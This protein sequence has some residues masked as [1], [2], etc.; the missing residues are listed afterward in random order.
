MSADKE[1]IGLPEAV[2]TMAD[3]R[4]TVSSLMKAIEEGRL[5]AQ[6]DPKRPGRKMVK[7]DDVQAM[8]NPPAEEPKVEEPKV[9]E[10]KVEEPKADTGIFIKKRRK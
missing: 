4:I 9:E 6:D 8:L 10:P 7:L 5:V 1:L 3:P 2:R